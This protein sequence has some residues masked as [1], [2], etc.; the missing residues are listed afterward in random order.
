MYICR[1][2]NEILN[3]YQMLDKELIQKLNQVKNL[4]AAGQP[5]R[6]WILLNKEILMSQVQPNQKIESLAEKRGEKIYYFQYFNNLFKQSIL[7]PALATVVIVF[8]L[9][10]YSATVSMAGVSLPGDK[11]YP[12]KTAQEKVQLALTFAEEEKVSLQMSFVS[13]R[14]DELGQLVKND[15][16]VSKK[17]AAVKKTA[18]RISKDVGDVKNKLDKIS[19]AAVAVDDEKIIEV[20]KEIDTKTLELKQ[21]LVE[22][23]NNLSPEVKDDVESAF[24]EAINT[25]EETGTSALNVI[26]KKYENDQTMIDGQD[27]A[28]RVADRIKDA[29]VSIVGVTK[30]IAKAATTTP[31][32]TPVIN[33]A[34]TTTTE[35][36]LTIQ[37]KPKVAQAV[38][39]QAKD[40]LDQKDFSSALQKVTETNKIV[41]T[42]EENVRVIVSE[43]NSATTTNSNNQ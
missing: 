40:L 3:Q 21:S 4:K 37:E 36:L 29:E 23:H 1:S 10:G 38:I 11:L 27:V 15:D 34:T 31:A 16:E 8:V 43:A 33:P 41:S 2:K 19:I 13:R 35:T 26:I 42:A 14:A 20:A 17:T 18:K 25:T 22:T 5:E 6:T 7:K 28:S 32:I 24:K 9:L 39:E 30:V 12:V